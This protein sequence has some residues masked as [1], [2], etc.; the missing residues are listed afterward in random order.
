M[1]GPSLVNNRFFPRANIVSGG[2]GPG[3]DAL[4]AV[5]DIAALQALDDTT[6]DDAGVVSMKSV[7]D[8]WMLDKTS[9][10]AVDGITVV[11]PNSGTGRWIRLE[12]PNETWQQQSTWHINETTGDDE[13]KGDTALLPVATYA[14]IDRRWGTGPVGP[15]V[16]NVDST[17]NQDIDVDVKINKAVGGVTFQGAR[18][19][20]YSGSVT[21][22]QAMNPGANQDAQITDAALPVSW[23]ASGLVGKLCVI[24]SGPRAGYAGWIVKDLGAKTARVTKFFD[25]AT[26]SFA[27]PQVGDA[28]DIVDLTQINGRFG[29][30]ESFT[31][32]WAFDLQFTNPGSRTYQAFGGEWFFFYC[33]FNEGSWGITDAVIADLWECRVACTTLDATD[34][35]LY[36]EAGYITRGPRGFRDCVC[37]IW[38]DLIAQYVSGTSAMGAEMYGP[39]QFIITSNGSYGVFDDPN[40]SS[41]GLSVRTGAAA[42]LQGYLWGTGNTFNYAIRVSSTGKI[43]YDLTTTPNAATA[44]LQDTKIGSMTRP[45]AALPTNNMSE[46]CGIVRFA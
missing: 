2:P 32:V 42:R 3:G 31:S 19:V 8:L 5:A 36:F 45:Y 9:T 35:Y 15:V 37:T 44:A 25:Y 39:S 4:L 16:I 26:F 43:S 10:L 12:I 38:E 14:E 23:T 20:I 22:A 24:T 41:Y 27:D 30:V 18:T 34:S 13:N 33:D 29:G 17:L 1:A 11:L 6:V 46:R 28:F 7:L 21:G 40:A